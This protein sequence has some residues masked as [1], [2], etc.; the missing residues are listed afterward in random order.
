M[1]RS[2][3][4]G[5][6]REFAIEFLKG[7]IHAERRSIFAKKGGGKLQGFRRIRPFDAECECFGHGASDSERAHPRRKGPNW[8]RVASLR[9]ARENPCERPQQ[10]KPSDF[11]AVTA[12][13][14]FGVAQGK[15]TC[16][17][18]FVASPRTF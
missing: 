4:A 1:G 18:E 5:K 13:L 16:P 12:R 9:R 17:D 8:P 6:R 14:P 2:V 11:A 15:K 3:S 7:K 10:L